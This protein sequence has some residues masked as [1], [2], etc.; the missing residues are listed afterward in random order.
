MIECY[1]I[2]NC[3]DEIQYE[4]LDQNNNIIYPQ[5]EDEIK[6]KEKKIRIIAINGISNI[7]KKLKKM[8]KYIQ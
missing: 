4:V 1:D 2:L 7:K 8:I 3:I 5:K 6:M